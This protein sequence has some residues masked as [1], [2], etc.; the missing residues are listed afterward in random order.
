M[1]DRALEIWP[2]IKKVAQKWEKITPSKTPKKKKKNYQTAITAIKDNLITAKLNYFSFIAS[3]FAAFSD[4][5]YSDDPLV[6]FIYDVS[7]LITS[8]NVINIQSRKS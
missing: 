5:V 7:S 8:L 6:L 2:N 4:Q 3:N 1:A